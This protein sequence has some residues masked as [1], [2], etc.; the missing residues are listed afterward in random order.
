MYTSESAKLLQ[1][2]LLWVDGACILGYLFTAFHIVFYY[3]AT[4]RERHIT[5]LDF[6]L[7]DNNVHSPVARQCFVSA[8]C[9]A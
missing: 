6:R 5:I 8:H 3:S 7:S 4:N 1:R 2:L 9:L